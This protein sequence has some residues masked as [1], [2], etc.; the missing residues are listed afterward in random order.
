MSTAHRRLIKEL[1][2]LT[3]ERDLRKGKALHAKI[4]KT[5][6]FSNVYLANCLVNLYAKCGQLAKAKL[7]FD[8]I[9]DKNE[10]SWSSIINAYAQQGRFESYVFVLDLFKQMR[11]ENS[12]PNAHS[13]AGVFTA[14]SNLADVWVGKQAH[15]LAIKTD[16]CGDVVVG[17]SILNMYCKSGLVTDARRMFDTMPERNSVSWSTMLSG[18]SSCCMAEEAMELFK[19][20]MRSEEEKG[21]HFL[22]TS[23]LSAF[24]VPAFVNAGRGIHCFA[25]K[26]GVILIPEVRNALL[27]MYMK[28]GGMS[29]ALQVFSMS[30]DKNPIT[31]SAIITGLAQI[32]NSKKALKLF[33]DMH[34]S[35]FK[36]S[37]YTFVGVINACSDISDVREGK[38]IHCYSV[39]MGFEKQIYIISALVDMYA[40]SN[41]VVD[42]RKCFDCLHA[43]DVVLW[44]SIIAGYVQ[45][46]DNE[47]ALSLYARME[48]EGIQPN[49]LTLASVLKGCSSLAALE[50]GKQI[51]AHAIKYGLARL[52]TIGSSLSSMYAK[53][54]CIDEGRVVFQRMTTRDVISWN[55]MI[56]G[57]A[58]NG[59]S[60]KA[61]EIFEDMRSEGVKPDNVTFVNVL[62]ACS[63][64]G[65]VD[66]SWEYFRMISGEYGLVPGLEHY[67]CMVDAYSRAGRLSEAKQFIESATIDHGM[68]LW[69]ILLGACRNYRHYE[70]GAYAGEKLME[71]GSQES[72]AYVMLSRIYVALG[73]PDDAE[74]IMGL[75]R[76]RR[77]AKEPG[78]SWIELKNLVHV[79][80]VGDQKHPEEGNI[81]SWL[82]VLTKQMID[83]GYKP[84]YDLILT[85]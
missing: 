9:N 26:A 7:A 4:I 22:L 62:S 41:H 85:T 50:Q 12:V 68:C 11:V 29:D 36:P 21:Y 23:M 6:S 49:D 43:P 52:V 54:G 56:S 47:E 44:T 39:K 66:K 82:R 64:M 58:Q 45:N 30:T 75:M 65:L 16:H 69:R 46:G 25:V 5:D 13:L 32:G 8:R 60:D 34:F 18:Y 24:T 48:A 17:S 53:C 80:V 74:R 40:K 31:W 28:C 59:C 70:L 42:A 57:L 10:I 37:E 78:C 79:F 20:V 72:S 33:S 71:L 1:V 51:H 2:N 3:Q 84:A 67:A 77:V 73:K 83:E 81:R 14:V 38:Q 19:M 61:L 63:H 27:T 15:S 35:G 55:V 76:L